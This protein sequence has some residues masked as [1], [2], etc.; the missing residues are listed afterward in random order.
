M[1]LPNADEGE[2]RVS[3]VRLDPDHNLRTMESREAGMPIVGKS[4]AVEYPRTIRPT[5]DVVSRFRPDSPAN[6]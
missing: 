3:D 1:T 4:C 2:M 6:S 5:S